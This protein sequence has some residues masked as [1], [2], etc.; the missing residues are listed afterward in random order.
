MVVR[1]RELQN[2]FNGRD[3]CISGIPNRLDFEAAVKYRKY[4][5]KFSTRRMLERFDQDVSNVLWYRVGSSQMTHSSAY[6]TNG[7]VDIFTLDIP[8]L[9]RSDTRDHGTRRFRG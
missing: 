8:D 6:R 1:L 3:I 2:V 4:V 9:Q 7:L 5:V